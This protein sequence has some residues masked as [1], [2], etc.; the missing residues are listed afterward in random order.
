MTETEKPKYI[1]S[2]MSKSI[3]SLF[4]K[5]RIRHETREE[6]AN[7]E[8]DLINNKYKQI[9]NERRDPFSWL[10]LKTKYSGLNFLFILLLRY[11]FLQK[12]LRSLLIEKL[13]HVKLI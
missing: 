10:N 9:L 5:W 2:C 12:S 6:I 1:M 4:E 8:N 3:E 11:L 7:H 13:N